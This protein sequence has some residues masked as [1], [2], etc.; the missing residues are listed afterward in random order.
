MQAPWVASLNLVCWSIMDEFGTIRRVKEYTTPFAMKSISR[1]SIFLL[2]IFYGPYFVMLAENTNYVI[3]IMFNCFTIIAVS[4]LFNI[5]ESIDSPFD[6]YG[7]DD[8]R[9]TSDSLQFKNDINL[10]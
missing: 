1:F 5:L 4:S 2:P 3:A 9:I 10:L 7:M 6:E 8:V